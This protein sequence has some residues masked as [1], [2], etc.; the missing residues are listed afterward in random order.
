MAWCVAPAKGANH[1]PA[2]VLNGDRTTGVLSV[3]A[4]PGEA[5]RLSA[6]GSSDPDGDRLNFRWFIYP[7]AGTYGRD[8]PIPGPAAEGVTLT[9]PADAAGRTIHVVLE[10]TDGGTPALTRY[11]RAVLTV[12]R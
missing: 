4:R 11:R 2:A 8:V 10:V 9:V 3:N 1:P 6:A 7:E 5:V 12:G